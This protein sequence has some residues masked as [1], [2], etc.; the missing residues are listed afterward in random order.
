VHSQM[1][2]PS[3]EIK[4]LTPNTGSSGDSQYR[5]ALV[6]FGHNFKFSHIIRVKGSNG[7]P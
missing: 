1:T 3:L 6:D 4:N 7:W 5:V 2:R